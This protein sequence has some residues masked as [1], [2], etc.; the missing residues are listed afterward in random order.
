M[1]IDRQISSHLKKMLEKYPVIFLTGPRQSGKTTLLRN[2]FGDFRYYNLER[3]DIREMI[4]ADP[5]GF[6]N[7]AGSK[8]IF[9]EA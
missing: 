2:V 6:L 8:L 5:V 9:D 4:S 7:S 3:P 1:I